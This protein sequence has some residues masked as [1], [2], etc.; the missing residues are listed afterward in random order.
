MTNTTNWVSKQ[1]EKSFFLSLPPVLLNKLWKLTFGK[2]ARGKVPN[3]KSFYLSEISLNR[4]CSPSTAGKKKLAVLCVFFFFLFL[5]FLWFTWFQ[6]Y[7]EVGVIIKI[8]SELTPKWVPKQRKGKHM[9]RI[10]QY[11]THHK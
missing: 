11:I 8:R 7:L 6:L 2:K 3:F 1:W 4:N 5:S 9:I 10:P